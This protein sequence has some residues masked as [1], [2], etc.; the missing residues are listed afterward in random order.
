LSLNL[1]NCEMVYVLQLC[2]CHCQSWILVKL[3]AGRK[4]RKGLNEV[5][6]SEHPLNNLYDVLRRKQVCTEREVPLSLNH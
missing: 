4:S 6:G 3:L 5:E 1:H 2:T